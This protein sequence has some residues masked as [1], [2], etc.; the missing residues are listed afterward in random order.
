MTSTLFLALL[1]AVGQVCA[2]AV[3]VIGGENP[4]HDPPV[5]VSPDATT[6][7]A[8]A[9]L[10]LSLNQAMFRPRDV[11]RVTLGVQNRGPA[12]N[13]DVYFGALLTD[14]VTVVF[15][16]SLSP[17][18]GVVT[19]LDAD[20]RTFRPWPSI[21]SSLKT[22]MSPSKT[23]C[24]YPSSWGRRRER[25]SRSPFSRGQA[26]RVMARSIQVTSSPLMQR[27][28]IF[29]CFE[30]LLAAFSLDGAFPIGGG[31]PMMQ[32]NDSIVLWPT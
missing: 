18:D 16:T 1:V 22:W 4:V 28:S 21:C 8:T 29:D 14:R 23:S 30:S 5:A 12:F 25:T 31:A 9:A 24:R 20:P 15:V 32:G 10:T 11:I 27:S 7:E 3:E 17:L 26:R 6:A 19:R 13:A 2:H